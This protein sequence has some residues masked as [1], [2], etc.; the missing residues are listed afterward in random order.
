MTTAMRENSF[1]KLPPLHLAAGTDELRPTLGHIVFDGTIA[2]VTNA[3]MLVRYDLSDYNF[4]KQLDGF[5]I[6]ATD[7]KAI[8]SAVKSKFIVDIRVDIEAKRLVVVSSYEMSF[9]LWK[10]SDYPNF[11]AVLPQP[12]IGDP[13]KKIG[14]NVRFL[15]ILDRIAGKP[16]YGLRFE[17][18]AENKSIQV[19]ASCNHDFY[20]MIMP[21][22]QY[23][24][25]PDVNRFITPP[26]TT[27][28]P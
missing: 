11:F 7:W 8:Q 21:A 23:D 24:C 2:T 15:N 6:K 13:I 22:M 1:K 27:P 14:L 18:Q 28:Q 16:D 25:F 3:Y 4:A 5:A 26:N 10:I 9:K 20:A 12:G 17:F 19:T